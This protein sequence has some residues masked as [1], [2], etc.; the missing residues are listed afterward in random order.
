MGVRR[1]TLD[2]I[3]R[4]A[5][6]R[7]FFLDPEQAGAYRDHLQSFLDAFDLVDSLPDHLPPVRY[8]RTGGYRPGVDEDPHNAWAQRTTV[9]GVADGPLRGRTVVLKDNIMLA[10]VPMTNGSRT[11]EGYVPE[12][13]ATVVTRVLDAGGT[14]VGKATCEGLCLSGGSHTSATGP[15]HNPYRRGYSAGGSSSGCAVLVALGTVDMAIGCDQGGSI[16]MPSSFC[17]T[18]GMKPTYGLV[19]YT[20][21]VPIEIT[22][23]HVG[24]MTLDVAANAAL[25]EVLAGPDGLDPRQVGV[26][27]QNY[28]EALGRGIAG[29]RVGVLRE[30]FSHPATEPDVAEAVRQAGAVLADLGAQV[31]EVSV[32]WHE[33][34]GAVWVPIGVGGI[35]HTLMDGDGFG[36]GR[37][38][39]Y[40]SSFMESIA[41][42][43]NTPMSFRRRSRASYCWPRSSTSTMA[44]ATT[45]RP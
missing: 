8:P 24:P 31:E 26:C 9:H 33:R 15:V 5:E 6:R 16:R 20:G 1:P 39:L 25:L 10:G 40:V 37:S 21:I 29:L 4:I 27:T 35:L 2:E 11:L 14:I 45:A 42:G 44:L 30:G 23:D 18:V 13:D 41:T 32:P 43:E 34:A 7:G 12:L 3:R 22:A 36:S 17:G 28:T 38:D 19:P